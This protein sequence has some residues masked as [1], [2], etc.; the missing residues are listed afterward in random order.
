MSTPLRLASPFCIHI[1]PLHSLPSILFH[2][3]SR[4]VS[5]IS[6]VST[7]LRFTSLLRILLC[8]F[9]FIHSRAESP[10]SHRCLHL[11][12]LHLISTPL[13]WASVFSLQVQNSFDECPIHA[14]LK[15][16]GMPARSATLCC[17]CSRCYEVDK[18]GVV[19][20]PSRKLISVAHKVAHLQRVQSR[21]S[22]SSEQHQQ[23]V[24]TLAWEEMEWNISREAADSLG[25]RVCT[26]TLTDEGPD[27]SSQASKLWTSCEDFQQ[28]VNAPPPI[29]VIAPLLNDLAESFTHLAINSTPSHPIPPTDN[30]DNLLPLPP[31]HQSSKSSTSSGVPCT[32]SKREKDRCTINTHSIL[33]N[34]ESCMQVIPIQIATSMSISSLRKIRTELSTLKTALKNITYCASSVVEH[35]KGLCHDLFL[36]VSHWFKGRPKV[37]VAASRRG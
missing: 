9:H 18:E 31:S 2:S 14:H 12:G 17:L 13:F 6:Q 28:N 29:D 35:K 23:A 15:L 27:L 20:N 36:L 10:K 7:P 11:W 25:G 32:T 21:L 33:A 34:I 24:E 1:T 16:P 26:L 22:I 37:K 8:L 4:R 3:L 19:H 5:E 30:I